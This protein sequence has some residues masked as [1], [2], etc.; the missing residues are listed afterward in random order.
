M[1]TDSNGDLARQLAALPGAVDQLSALARGAGA[2]VPYV[3]V[4]TSMRVQAAGVLVNV[5]GLAADPAR[6]AQDQAELSRVVLPLLLEQMV[7]DPATLQQACAALATDSKP[8]S[9]AEG[10]DVDGEASAANVTGARGSGGAAETGGEV[11]MEDATG[12]HVAAAVAAATPMQVATGGAVVNGAGAPEAETRGGTKGT[13]AEA[14]ERG[15]GDDGKAAAAVADQPDR[16]AEVRWGWKLGVAEPLKLT[17]EVLTNLCALAAAEG[18]EEDDEEEWGSDDEDAMEQAASGD[19]GQRQGAGRRQGGGGSPPTV[20]LDAMAEGGALHRTLQTLR[21]LLSPT[22]RDQQASAGAGGGEGAMPP[23][24]ADAEAVARLS[25]PSGTAGDLAD[26]RATVALCAANLVQNLPPKA[27]GGDPNALWVELCGMC[28]AAMERAPSCVETLTG[29]MWGLARRTGPAIAAGVSTAAAATAPAAPAAVMADPLPLLLRLCDPETTRAFEARVNAVG[30]L[31]VLGDAVSEPG[32]D[33]GDLGIGRALT[34]AMEDPHV[35]V[36]AEALNAVMDVYGDDGRDAA[37][38]GS[39]APAA[40][41][42]G[43]PA[44]R[45]KV[46]QEGKALGRDA[47]CHLKETAL[48]ASRFLKYKQAFEARGD[49]D[50][51]SGR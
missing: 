48:N 22:P 46:K 37:F 19:A 44:F 33:A 24:S 35:L 29:V 13:R 17:A 14:D 7:Y 43:V 2:D 16:D 49:A 3:K 25:L 1:A 38:R 4:S 27:L 34:Q 36:Q 50:K 47:L 30:M 5:A 32:G 21:E 8:A 11:E 42:A 31:G 28:E 6:S 51:G 12:A 10:M 39:G 40:L 15:E 9:D 45:R 23:P 18:E 20:L 41:L 26:L